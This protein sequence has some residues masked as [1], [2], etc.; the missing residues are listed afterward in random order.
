MTAGLK[1][2]LRLV[3][4]DSLYGIDFDGGDP[5]GGGGGLR[6]IAIMDTPTPVIGMPRCFGSSTGAGFSFLA[7]YSSLRPLG[8]LRSRF[9]AVRDWNGMDRVWRE[10]RSST[11]SV[12]MGGAQGHLPLR[13][14]HY[15]RDFVLA[16]QM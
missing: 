15:V 2:R 6:A 10:P 7:G 9:G 14:C 5:G 16:E 11:V 8:F 3:S 13:H 4:F 12:G 1:A